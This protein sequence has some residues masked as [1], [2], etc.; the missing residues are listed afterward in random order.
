[1]NIFTDPVSSE[2]FHL[3]TA[4]YFTSKLTEKVDS[5]HHLSSFITHF[6][7]DGIDDIPYLYSS[8]IWQHSEVLIS[9]S[10]IFFSQIYST[11]TY[12]LNSP[13]LMTVFRVSSLT[14]FLKTYLTKHTK[15]LICD[16]VHSIISWSYRSIIFI[17][18]AVKSRFLM[19]RMIQ[20]SF[21]K[22]NLIER[23][24]YDKIETNS[25]FSF[26]QVQI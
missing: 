4:I 11:T 9:P 12:T 5:A 14:T 22:R 21:E 16:F 17:K 1:M 10:Q 23:F 18:I 2:E 20:N 19:W 8:L 13:F 24:I 15:I 7:S 26:F 3:R 25:W 6:I